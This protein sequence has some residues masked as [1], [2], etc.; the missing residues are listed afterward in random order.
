MKSDFE[1]VAGGLRVTGSPGMPLETVMATYDLLLE[2][3]RQIQ[4]EGFTAARDDRFIDKQL[5]VAAACYAASHRVAW[6][7]WLRG[8]RLS[9][10]LNF[11]APKVADYRRNLVKAGALII[12]EIERLDRARNK[13]P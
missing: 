10:P 2:R 13:Q 7:P 5:G 6:H 3:R 9:W 12:A 11:G 8:L 1:I 4:D